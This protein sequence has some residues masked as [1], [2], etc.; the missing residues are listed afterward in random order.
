ML[1]WRTHRRFT[2]KVLRNKKSV[3]VQSVY[4]MVTIRVHV[5]HYAIISGHPFTLVVITKRLCLFFCTPGLGIVVK[6]K[7]VPARQHV[8]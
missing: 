2:H 4:F 6:N 7:E 5:N 8:E 1:I 3:T